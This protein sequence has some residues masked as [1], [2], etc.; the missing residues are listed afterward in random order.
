MTWASTVPDALNGLLVALRGTAALDGVA[1]FDG[2]VV[3]GS[4]AMEVITVGYTGGEDEDSADATEAI[5]GLSVQQQRERYTVR[6]AA[7]VRNGSADLAAARNRA[8]ELLGYVGGALAADKRLG[9]AV[10]MA[11]LGAHQLRQA[12]DSRGA[13]ATVVFEV[14]VDAMTRS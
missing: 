13:L 12:Q 8:Y 7:S 2:P 5:T 11:S 10:M 14:A 9:G 6:C 1:V 3:S 4:T